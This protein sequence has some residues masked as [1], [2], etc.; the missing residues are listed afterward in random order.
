MAKRTRQ[1]DHSIFRLVIRNIEGYGRFPT[2]T[3][4]TKRAP[5]VSP[6]L[7]QLKQRVLDLLIQ[8]QS[9]RKAKLYRWSVAWQTHAASGLP[10]LDLLV[11]YDKNFQG[12]Y[13]AYD[14]LIKK[15]NIQQRDVGDDVG[16]GH[17]WVTPYSSKKLN[18]AILQYSQK[19][20]P[21]PITNL[22]LQTKED[23]TRVH[24]L[25]ADPYR[26]L[27][28]QMLKDPIH[29]S[30]EQYVRKN[31]LYQYI[32]NWSSIKTKL[33]DSQQA[34]ANLALKQKLGFCYISRAL[35]QSK[36]SVSELCTFDSWGG[37]QIIVNYLNQ[38]V[39]YGCNRPFKS[40]QLLLVGKPNTGKTSLVRKI[41]QYCATYHLDVSNWFP[42]YR[43]GVY[44]LFF[45]DQ[46]KLKGGMSHTD[47]LKFLQG[48]P[49]DLQYKGGSSLR[50][51]NQLIIMTSNLS[52]QS[53]I[54][55]KFKDPMLNLQAK[56]NLGTRIQ[57]VV[58]PETFDLFLLLSLIYR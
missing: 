37:Y 25:K 57:E 42:N 39:T 32:S 20:D 13:T 6:Q 19:E 46:F 12:F 2:P 54:D 3:A 24:K 4:G 34:A 23:L 29:F 45:W 21:A 33:K 17:V 28:L 53:H 35:L 52:L 15:L 30:V 50:M 5:H 58:I 26:Y 40:K 47:L 7:D 41:Q 44:S 14:Y 16:V 56:S 9:K 48:S 10:H 27:E 55:L 22:T 51:D 11:V 36:L 18:K 8:K 31:D 43:D 38:I 49:M 1:F